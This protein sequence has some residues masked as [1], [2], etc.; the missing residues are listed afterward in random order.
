MIG[1]T[2]SVEHVQKDRLA[3]VSQK[4]DYLLGSGCDS[5]SV[6]PLR[7]PTVAKDRLTVGPPPKPTQKLNGP[8]RSEGLSLMLL[9]R[10]LDG[11]RGPQPIP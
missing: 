11:F 3:A 8:E 4:T 7:V 9:L 5:S 6:L 1:E 10:V 2:L